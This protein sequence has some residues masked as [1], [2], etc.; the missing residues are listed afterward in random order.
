MDDHA[1]ILV[2]VAAAFAQTLR[3]ALQRGLTAAVGV[4]GAT[5][6]R[7]LFGLPFAFV[8][9]AAIAGLSERTPP[10][11]ND[12]ALAWI[13]LGAATQI[14]ATA[15]MLAAM[16]RRSF[17]VVTALTKTEPVQVLLVALVALGEVP[18]AMLV[19]AVLVATLGVLILSW[20]GPASARAAGGLEAV[21]FGLGSA[22]LF[23]V[24]AVAYRG[25][26]LA[27]DG[28]D[29]PLAAATALG[30]ALTLQATSLGAWLAWRNRRALVAIAH[31]WR[32]SLLAG[33]LGAAASLG[34]FTAFA[35]QET[36]AVRT[37]ALVELLFAQL[38]SL[39]LLRERTTARETFGLV[40]LVLGVALVLN[41]D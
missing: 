24:S 18:T 7:F 28:A 11:P 32:P 4:I 22:A 17:V 31:A 37:L 29:D 5:H 40:L 8:F 35:L 6:V 41:V 20:P 16:R 9:L 26:I 23:A 19:A 33:L 3:N 15:L 14:G 13:T 12:M 30:L 34:W 2:T 1:W 27:M 25:G 21:V 38:I 39:R 36:A 10:L